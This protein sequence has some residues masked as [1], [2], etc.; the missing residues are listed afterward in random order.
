MRLKGSKNKNPR[1]PIDRFMEKVFILT[2]DKGCWIWTGYIADKMPYGMIGSGGTGPVVGAHRFSW[3]LFRGVIPPGMCVLHSCDNPKCVNPDHL[4]LGTKTDNNRDR[5]RKGRQSKGESQG[6][7]VLTEELVRKIRSLYVPRKFSSKRI[8][9]LLGLPRPA[10]NWVII[11]R[12]W[13]H[14]S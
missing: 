4:F 2:Y 11:G 12:S 9:D 3:T 14:V 7:A 10:V 5:D 13:K 8:S 1:N 6:N